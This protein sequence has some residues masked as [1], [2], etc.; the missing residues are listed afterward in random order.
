MVELSV[1]EISP[2]GVIGGS[3]RGEYPGGVGSSPDNGRPKRKSLKS[4]RYE[5]QGKTN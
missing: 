1:A 3:M 2:D 5:K 4:T